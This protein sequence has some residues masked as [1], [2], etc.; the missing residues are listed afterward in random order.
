MSHAATA[1]GAKIGTSRGSRLERPK[2]KMIRVRV[3]QE[4][5][6]ER[7]QIG[8]RNSGLADPRQ[9]PAQGVVE[10]RVGEDPLLTNID[11]K[12]SMADVCNAHGQLFTMHV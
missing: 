10:V 6:V 4:D 9:E 5:R 8:Q 12:R 2:R 11:E 3:S 1:G 7:R